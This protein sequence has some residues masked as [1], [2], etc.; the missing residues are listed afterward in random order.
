MTIE[1]EKRIPKKENQK[2]EEARPP[3]KERVN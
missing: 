1:T 2:R 3:Q